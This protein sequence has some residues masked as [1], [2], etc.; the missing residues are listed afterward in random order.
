M[1]EVT[2]FKPARGYILVKRK[3]LEERASGIVLARE[4]TSMR[5][6]VVALGKGRRDGKG[7]DIP[8][9]VKI[10]DEVLME[11]YQITEVKFGSEVYILTK[12]ETISCVFEGGNDTK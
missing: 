1:M 10:G 5:A 3:P 11:M 9:N 8:M 6:I 2:N 12:E 7:G 4:E